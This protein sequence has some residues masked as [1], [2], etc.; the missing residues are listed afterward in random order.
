MEVNLVFV[1]DSCHTGEEYLSDFHKRKLLKLIT[2]SV[3]QPTP[4]L[5]LQCEDEWLECLSSEHSEEPQGRVRMM[6]ASLLL[7]LLRIRRT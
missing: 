5:C 4:Q 6:K 1:N 3:I 7:M 2:R